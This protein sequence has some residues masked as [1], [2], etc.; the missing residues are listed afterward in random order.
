MKLNPWL[1]IATGIL[2]RLA[3]APLMD[4]QQDGNAYATMAQSLH[5]HGSFWMPW[6]DGYGSGLNP[7]PSHHY[8]PLYPVYLAVWIA[9]FGFH[10]WTLK[11]ANLVLSL[12]TLLICYATTRNLYGKDTALLTTGLFALIPRFIMAQGTGFSENLVAATFI[13]TLWAGIK[14][15]RDS[16][17]LVLA[18]I[19]AGL[20]FLT[21]SG[22]GPF[23]FLGIAA[24]LAWRL[25]YA[26]VRGTLTNKWYL[27][28]GACFSLLAGAWSI[29]NLILFGDWQ[30]SHYLTMVTSLSLQMPGY[31]ALGLLFKSAQYILV[32]YLFYASFKPEWRKAWSRIHEETVS[33]LWLSIALAAILGAIIAGMI[34]SVER[35]PPFWMDS[36]RYL[37]IAYLPLLWLLIPERQAGFNAR[38]AAIAAVFFLV[39]VF[40]IIEPTRSVEDQAASHLPI[41]AGQTLGVVDGEAGLGRYSFYPYLKERNITL[42]LCDS[43]SCQASADY[44]MGVLP[45]HNANYT[46]IREDAIH[47]FFGGTTKTVTTYRRNP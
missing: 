45:F 42:T 11:A 6:G 12:A 27:V 25:R 35:S 34:W 15:L 26:G 31:L 46:A 29:R 41:K 18:G 32:L 13:L 9:G 17:Y 20:A 43:N 24:G 8:P 37:C 28:G 16:R 40:E 5:T 14:G 19:F 44:V 7:G 21:R 38:L 1:L 39:N 23:F 4:I 22:M 10:I 47:F 2:L 33:L 3:A 30:S 36:E